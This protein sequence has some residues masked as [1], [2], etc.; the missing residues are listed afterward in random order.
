M[1]NLS[2]CLVASEKELRVIVYHSANHDMVKQF[3]QMGVETTTLD[4]RKPAGILNQLSFLL[5]LA[6]LFSRLKP[7]VIH[8]QYI[9]PGLL[10]ILAAWLARVPVILATV[11]QINS[12]GW[13]ARWLLRFASRFTDAFFCVSEAVE[14]SWFSDSRIFE[15]SMSLNDRRH[16]TIHNPVAVNDNSLINNNTENCLA[17]V[18]PDGVR[19]VGV[20]GRL[21]GEKG[22]A[23]LLEAF[24]KLRERRDDLSLKVVGDGPD[25]AK[26][27]A[28]ARELGIAEFVE[29]MGS[30]PPEEVRRLYRSM[31]VVV[32]P[33]LAEGFGLVAAEALSADRPVVASDV[34]GLAE[35]VR[36]E[37]TGLL[38]PP[39]DP[40]AL[41][42]AIARILDNSTFAEGLARAGMSDVRER[43]SKERFNV[44]FSAVYCHFLR[45]PN[46]T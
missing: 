1:L 11:H 25:R 15:P 38:V 24:A 40:Q 43:F 32:V 45:L 36:H 44:A 22:Q 13:K 34:G 14:G 28:R 20:V 42:A 4:W 18:R 27:E 41:S 2:E 10:P 26:L 19:I 21:R 33:S 46:T 30:R 5:R 16:W 29:W 39:G 37:Q 3:S 9:A 8:V 23:V 12:Y 31:D 17:D 6:R 35:V 7:K